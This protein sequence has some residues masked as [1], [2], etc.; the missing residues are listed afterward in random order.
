MVRQA[1]AGGVTFYAMDVYGLGV[2][3]GNTDPD[4]V[5]HSAM[6]SSESMLSYVAALSRQNRPGGGTTV[7]TPSA[8]SNAAGGA[9]AAAAG[10]A[11][12]Q[13]PSSASPTA[14]MMELAHQDDYLKFMV[15]S[16]NRQEAIRE[17][18]ERTGGFL[19]ANTNNTDKLLAHV[20]EEVDT[21][22]EIAYAPVLERE[23]G[24][25]RKIEVKLT[26]PDLKVE[27]RSGY[28]AVPA[29]VEGPLTAEEM[30]GLR[31]LDT[32]PRPHA[33]DFL[34][35]AYRFRGAGGAAQYAIAFEMPLSNLTA[36]VPDAGNKR[37]LHASLQI[38]RAHV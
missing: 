16:G 9:A 35:R 22:Y 10:A 37:R 7:G 23:D 13:G 29:A 26:R 28:Y 17:L 8:V 11:A 34:L 38:G 19:I 1:V 27:T 12:A 3:Q 31:A 25:F 24:R 20:M 30:V 32:E 14:Q 18:A 2:C 15:S 6:A 21:H 5:A 36:A 4:C 33:F